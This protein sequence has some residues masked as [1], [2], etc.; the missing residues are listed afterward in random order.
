MKHK[1]LKT[2]ILENRIKN[3]VISLL[4]LICVL[5]VAFIFDKLIEFLTF[6]V[7]YT[8]IRNEFTK[9]IHGSDF[10][11]SSHK[12][13]VLC[14]I[15]TTVIQ[16]ISII[17]LI[18]VDISKFINILLAGALGVVNFFSKDY[19]EYKIKKI[20]FYKG[21]LAEDIPKEL[22]GIEYEIILQYY[23]KRYKLDKIDINL[24]YS[25]DNIKKIKANILKRY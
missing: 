14:R 18:K 1:S 19:L 8:V 9:A 11:T 23:V 3:L 2:I 22:V 4:H 25:V 6:M 15:I 10:T 12:G 21:M 20:S 17:F 5:I 13:I 16:L 24:H 7:T